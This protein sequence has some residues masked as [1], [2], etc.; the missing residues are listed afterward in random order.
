MGHL[1][2]FRNGQGFFGFVLSQFSL[3]I[4]CFGLQTPGISRDFLGDQFALIE[5]SG[6][7]NLTNFIPPKYNNPPLTTPHENLSP[8]DHA[9]MIERKILCR[10]ALTRA[11]ETQTR[12]YFFQKYFPNFVNVDPPSTAPK[13]HPLGS[14]GFT[15][16][17]KGKFK[18]DRFVCN[19][20]YKQDQV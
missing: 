15:G 14:F 18:L 13:I 12:P 8:W 10:L 7:Q 5:S 16:R 1:V 4:A 19:F 11:R 3:N 20:Y 9:Q 2:N 17:R 6:D